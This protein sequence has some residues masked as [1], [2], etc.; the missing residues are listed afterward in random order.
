MKQQQTWLKGLGIDTDGPLALEDGSGLSSYDR[1]SPRDLVTILESLAD[2]ARRHDNSTSDL[3]NMTF[4]EDS[5][6]ESDEI[7]TNIKQIKSVP[8]SAAF[9]EYGV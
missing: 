9:S 5:F 3:D 7:T 1:I 2:T 6:S 4:K 8:L